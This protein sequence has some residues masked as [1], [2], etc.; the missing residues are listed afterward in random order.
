[1]L[2]KDVGTHM[3]STTVDQ[4]NV[5]ISNGLMQELN[6]DP[7]RSTHV[8]HGR[9]LSRRHDTDGSSIILHKLGFHALAT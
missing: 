4:L 3:V 6:V 5:T 8:A 2:R 1:M 7:V 9:V